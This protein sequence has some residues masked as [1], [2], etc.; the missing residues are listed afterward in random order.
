MTDTGRPDWSQHHLLKPFRR[1]KLELPFTTT[2]RSETETQQRVLGIAGITG[3]VISLSIFAVLVWAGLFPEIYR[4]PSVTS[5]PPDRDFLWWF[6]PGVGLAGAVIILVLLGSIMFGRAPGDGHP[7]T[8][9]A[10][11]D[12]LTVTNIHGHVFSGPWADWRLESVDILHMP[13]A[14]EVLSVLHLSVGGAQIATRV[15]DH[16]KQIRFLRMVAQKVAE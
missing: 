15:I 7:L 9:A 16:R 6:I 4:H 14:G 2:E 3:L 11:E 5:T 8:F 13:R 12:G 1:G 10:T